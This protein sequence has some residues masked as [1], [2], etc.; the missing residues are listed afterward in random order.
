MT[1]DKIMCILP[2]NCSRGLC[3]AARVSVPCLFGQNKAGFILGQN[4]WTELFKH[5]WDTIV[6]L[7]GGDVATVTVKYTTE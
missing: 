4:M 3:E 7:F 2:C 1:V 6:T 5:K